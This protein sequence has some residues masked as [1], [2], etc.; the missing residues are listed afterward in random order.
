MRSGRIS[1]P[2]TIREIASRFQSIAN[3]P[4]ESQSVDFDADRAAHTLLERATYLEEL[5]RADA[6]YD[7]ETQPDW[8]MRSQR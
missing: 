4:A 8:S 7:N 3:N 1:D 5:A 2:D 6:D